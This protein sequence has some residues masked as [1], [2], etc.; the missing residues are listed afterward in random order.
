[1]EKALTWLQ[2]RADT[3]D[4]DAM[5]NAG[6]MLQEAGRVEKAL[7]W[8]QRAADTGHPNAVY[9]AVEMLRQDGRVEEGTGSASPAR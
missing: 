3:G 1:M 2:Q 8:Y 5:R 7:T 9:D 6:W 4:Q